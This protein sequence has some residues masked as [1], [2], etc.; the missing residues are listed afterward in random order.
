MGAIV[1]VLLYAVLDYLFLRGEIWTA[2]SQYLPV[3][4]GYKKAKD[5]YELGGFDAIPYGIIT[6][7]SMQ[8]SVVKHP[9]IAFLLF[10]SYL[11][12]SFLLDIF[13]KID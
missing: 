11:L 7:W 2:F 5:Y 12:N 9:L 13:G 4:D 10:P 1:I 3:E 6:K 8:Y